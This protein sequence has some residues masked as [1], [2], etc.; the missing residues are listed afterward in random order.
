MRPL[1]VVFLAGLL[2]TVWLEWAEHDPGA[3]AAQ[4][5]LATSHPSGSARPLSP[6]PAPAPA[7]PARVALGKDLFHDPRLSGDQSVSCASCHVIAEGGDD[8]RA[9]S[10][11]AGGQLSRVNAPTVLN[12]ALHFRQFWDGRVATLEAQ[13]D[14]PLLA[15]DEMASSWETALERLRADPVYVARFERLYS[16]P[17]SREAVR[18]ALATYERALLTPGP[19]DRFLR[20]EEDALSAGQRRGYALFSR[21]GCVSCHQGA[22]VGGNMYQRLGIFGD[23]FADRGGPVTQADLGRF[24]VTGVEADR[25]VFKVPG[26]RNVAQTAP[27]FHDG[28]TATLEDAV[29]TMARYQLGRELP[30]ADL[31]DL[32]DFLGSLSGPVP[33][34]LLGTP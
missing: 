30:E 24:Q 2:A 17:P 27:Y 11:G 18:D 25:H 5:E 15:T 34:A 33:A 29:R 14:G 20:G 4:A 1:G 31:R 32:V 7:D 16:T 28:S 13:V 3:S 21:Y 26:L 23:Y 19:I 8:G 10:V 9:R 12:A 22:G 6:L